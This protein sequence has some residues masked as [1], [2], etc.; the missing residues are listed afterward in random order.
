MSL[1]AAQCLGSLRH[2]SVRFQLNSAQVTL[3]IAHTILLRHLLDEAEATRPRIQ[4]ML[5][6]CVLCDSVHSGGLGVGWGGTPCSM[7]TR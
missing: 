7:E 5:M 4:R 6:R 3:R 2:F 1:S